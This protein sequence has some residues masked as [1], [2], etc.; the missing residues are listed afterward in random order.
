MSV[1]LDP[2]E[3][4]MQAFEEKLILA[5]GVGTPTATGSCLS[6][7]SKWGSFSVLAFAQESV[8]N[9]ARVGIAIIFQLSGSAQ[10]LPEMP[11]AVVGIE[12]EGLDFAH[13][14]ER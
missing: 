11:F 3:S 10:C 9:R 7:R 14:K 8:A 6:F 4:R 2:T 13:R 5:I 1:R 12:V